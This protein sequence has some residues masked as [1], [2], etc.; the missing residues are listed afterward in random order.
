MRLGASSGAHGLRRLG[1]ELIV[2]AT[3]VIVL[4]AALLYWPVMQAYTRAGNEA[5]DA[6]ANAAA[7]QLATRYSEPARLLA[8][9]ARDPDLATVLG[10][11]DAGVRGQRE[12]ELAQFFPD[13]LRVRLLPAGIED[14]EQAGNPPLGYACL[15]LLRRAE[16]AP[17][18]EV[19]L[20]GTPHQHVDYVQRIVGQGATTGSLLVS[21]PLTLLEQPLAKLG[22]GGYALRQESQGHEVALA[23][24]GAEQTTP[25]ARSLPVE[26]T[27]WLLAY[28][29]EAGAAGLGI[30]WGLRHWGLALL[31]VALFAAL[32]LFFLRRFS[33]A[34][35]EDLVTTI[36]LF[37]DYGEGHVQP[38]YAARLAETRGTLDLLQR[39]AREW[40]GALRPMMV[41]AARP[42]AAMEVPDEKAQDEIATLLPKPAHTSVSV[43]PVIFR[44]YDI[45]GV[46]NQNLGPEVVTR[47][48][49]SIGSQALALGQ[50]SVI[51]ARD[52]RL[53]GPTLSAALAQGLRASGVDVVDLGVAPT[54]VLYF[55]THY[56]NTSSGVM[57]TGSHNPPDYNGL[58][59]VLRGE[60]LA[61]AGIRALYER[62][63]SGE[64]TRGEGTYDAV[65]IL[66]DYIERITD[67]VRPT[68]AL[69]VVVDCGNGVAG[70]IAPRLLKALGC[71][72]TELYCEV[73]GRFPNHHPDP[74]R[75]ENVAELRAKVT[76][77]GAD[78]GLAFDGD[79]D[80]L[81]VIDS[82][83]NII[84][85]DRVLML[86]AMDVLGRNP[87]AEII[88][89][90]KCTRHLAGIIRSHGGKPRIWKTGH[91]L[92]KAKLKE[93]G[94]LLAGEM[95]GHIFFRERWFGFDDAL[96]AAAR[97][98]EVLA[99][100][101]HASRDVFAVLPDSINTPE[102]NL[103][104]AEG[105]HH[106]YMQRLLAEARIEGA[107]L[108]TIDGLRADFPDGFG[109][110]RASNTTPCLVLRFEGDTPEALA[111]IQSEFRRMMRA[112][113]AGLEMPF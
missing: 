87:G 101:P 66:P 90:V 31:A 39:I 47:V 11:P 65:D 55:A 75:P 91:S 42:P 97:L 17:G 62:I 78:V 58:K 102:I 25:P 26:G 46:V 21:F 61:E 92:I 18:A 15:D 107:E 48:A 59:I 45:R 51:I 50:R 22:P 33:S 32:L 111:R 60:T 1:G 99:A 41:P 77:L 67:D 38:S 20:P 109:L 6:R 98:V 76:Q 7:A 71:E 72:V 57:L 40:G 74:S 86:L 4:F 27:R 112:V 106:A 56:L 35:H 36:G 64:M 68:R 100:D 44:A 82:A 96:Y 2:S 14:I 10:N 12:A 108:T 103:K 34:L 110:V 23:W 49:Q 94:A 63:Q 73:D 3:L 8:L 69:K 83:G 93:T 16:E 9:L 89:D 104:M 95:S 29:P 30:G 28:W 113:D 43:D 13:A 81:G 53:S 70:M 52:G 105:E 54:P 79:G 84:W 80:R 85:P 37:K 24:H 19:H 88:Y 5:L